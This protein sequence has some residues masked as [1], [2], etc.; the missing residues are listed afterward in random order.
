M[1]LAAI[2]PVAMFVG[3][4]LFFG[5]FHFGLLSL[6]KLAIWSFV[7]NFIALIG[8]AFLAEFLAPKF[9][10]E[11]SRIGAFKLAAAA[12]TPYWI[13]GVLAIVPTAAPLSII[14]LLYGIFLFY[15]G[16]TPLLKIPQDKAPV[17][18]AAVVVGSLILFAVTNSMA[19][20]MLNPFGLGA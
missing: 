1:P 9:E 2:G 4:S 15:Q 7:L 13:A 18:T 20:T 14:G 6:T 3:L 8:S 12:L 19:M 10:G 11:A 17:F 16:S 5:T